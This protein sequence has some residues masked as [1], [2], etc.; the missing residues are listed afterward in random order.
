MPA[1]AAG[2]I[3]ARS[4]HDH[5]GANV[6]PYRSISPCHWHG[7]G[8]PGQSPGRLSAGCLRDISLIQYRPFHNT[9]P[10]KLAELWNFGRLGPGAAVEFCN[11][12]LE[13]IFS[14]PYFD[15]RGMIVACDGDEVVGFAHA[16]FGSNAAG[17]D[18][19]RETGVISTVLVRLDYRRRGIGREL[20]QRAEAYLR[21]QG[22]RE[23]YAGES[24]NRNPFY[25][26]LYGGAECAGFLESDA[27]AGP[28]FESFGYVP[29]ERYRL[30]RR[31]ITLKKDPFDPRC[32]SI[33]R[34]MK[35]G[36]MD[37]PP[38][39]TWWWMTRHGRFESLTFAL[40]PNNGGPPPAYVTCWGMELHAA[41][42]GQR[43]V[44]ITNVQV[45]DRNRRKG[46][47]KALLTEV[48]RRLRDDLVTHVEVTIR[49]DDAPSLALFQSL[50]FEQQDAGVVYK[51]AS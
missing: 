18:V 47:A 50:A 44:G 46:Y 45:S 12:A 25:L 5:G 30:L 27:A 3:V 49:A 36:V 8:S 34:S 10:P 48:I 51:K 21:E 4:N 16:G 6:G 33:K 19:S 29:A 41:T 24:G 17:N 11:D 40:I 43:I 38:D 9:D 2:V 37:H 39:A 20:V 14:E 35:F 1:V 26:G 31:D 23:I 42:R 32:V 22:A 28:F 7:P 15:R 13:L